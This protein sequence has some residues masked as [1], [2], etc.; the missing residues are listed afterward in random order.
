MSLSRIPL[1]QVFRSK[2]GSIDTSST[3]T[4][5]RSLSQSTKRTSYSSSSSSPPPVEREKE[6]DSRGRSGY[7][8]PLNSQTQT[9]PQYPS[10]SKYQSQSQTKGLPTFGSISGFT[11]SNY[12]AS[13]ATPARGTRTPQML[14]YERQAEERAREQ[15]AMNEERERMLE[16]QARMRAEQDRIAQEEHEMRQY[17]EA[18]ALKH[19]EEVRIHQEGKIACPSPPPLSLSIFINL[20]NRLYILGRGNGMEWLIKRSRSP[21]APGSGAGAR[22]PGPRS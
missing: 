14:E 7:P 22:A 11:L 1:E 9:K 21:K 3:T 20:E 15:D 13:M 5:T 6:G 2:P 18:E 4:T 12:F 17:Y 8:N 16:E 10:Q 19:A